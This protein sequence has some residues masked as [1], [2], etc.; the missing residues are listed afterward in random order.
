MEPQGRTVEERLA[1][2]AAGTYGVVIRCRLLRRGDL[3]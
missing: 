1:L 3:H 2:M